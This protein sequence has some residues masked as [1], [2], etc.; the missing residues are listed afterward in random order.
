M[1]KIILLFGFLGL[2]FSTQVEGQTYDN[3]VG[4]RA[5][6]GIGGTFKHF[7]NESAAGEVIVNYRSFGSVG[8]KWNFFRITGL[9]EVHKDLSEVLDG[10]QWYYGGGAFF[11]TWGGDYVGFIDGENTYIGISGVIG[12]DYAFTDIPL[13]IS[14]DWIPSIALVGG[15]GFVG[16]SG[17]V[18]V[19]YTF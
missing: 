4:L 16:E 6:W 3:A 17:G 5:A 12:L 14:V 11:Q 2:L 8:F 13:N 19:R 7:F 9:Y 15:G 1:K 18:A 10:L